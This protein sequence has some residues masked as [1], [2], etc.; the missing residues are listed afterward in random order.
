MD[1]YHKSKCHKIIHTAAASASAIAAGLAQLP[2]SDSIPITGIQIAMIISLGA[3]FGR[4]IARSAAEG[5]LAGAVAAVGGRTASQFLVGWIPIWGN[6]INAATAATIT[7]GIGWFVAESFSQAA[8]AQAEAERKAQAEAGR[9]AQTE[10]KRDASESSNYEPQSATYTTKGISYVQDIPVIQALAGLSTSQ[11]LLCAAFSCVIVALCVLVEVILKHFTFHFKIW[12]TV[13]GVILVTALN[14]VISVICSSKDWQS[15][16]KAMMS[17][18]NYIALVINIVYS[19]V[20]LPRDLLDVLK[21]IHGWEEA[22]VV[23]LRL[24][25][26]NWGL[27]IVAVLWWF[28]LK[29]KAS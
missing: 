15:Q 10:T 19:L 25:F 22:V 4:D 13:S 26:L 8:E 20:M 24:P 7:E 6:A 1:S 29:K 3:A 27:I 9:K 23:I 16:S 12:A 5:I 18:S 2:G 14:I 21:D 17:Y 28:N 11:M